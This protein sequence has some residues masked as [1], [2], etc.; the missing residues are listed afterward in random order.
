MFGTF[1]GISN[2]RAIANSAL[3][4]DIIFGGQ[5]SGV[6]LPLM[7]INSSETQL[8]SIGDPSN[9]GLQQTLTL[10]GNGSTTLSF[11]GTSALSPL[12]V[13][14]GLAGTTAAQVLA[15]LVTI[16]ALGGNEV[17][18]IKAVGTG[19][20]TFSLNGVSASAALSFQN[21][22]QTFSVVA[23]GTT[24]LSYNGVNATAPLSVTLGT[25]TAAAIQSNLSTI[26]ALSGNITVAPTA[27]PNVFNITFSGALAGVDA[28]Q[29]QSNTLATATTAT[30]IDGS[31]PTA[32]A[33]QANLQ[34]IP[35]LSGNEVQTLAIIGL[36]G[37]ATLS[38]NNTN[39]TSPLT[40][41][42]N[43]S[44]E[45]VLANLQTIPALSNPNDL[46]VSGNNGGPFTIVFTG[47]LAGQNV[48]QI[49]SSDT[50][51]ATTA[52]TIDGG[53]QVVSVTGP[54]GG[55]LSVQFIGGATGTKRQSIGE[56]HARHGH[57]S[58]D[59]EWHWC[60]ERNPNLDPRN[61][62]RCDPVVQ[63][64]QRKCAA[65]RGHHDD[66]CSNPG[67]PGF[68]SRLE[69][70]RGADVEPSWLGGPGHAV[71]QRRQC[72]IRDLD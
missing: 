24:L 15:N 22:V 52:T 46:T 67:P 29:I 19:T 71:L 58:D 49:A 1:N 50:T 42:P 65:D 30:T 16:P 32:A 6:D 27:D 39:A 33:V 13:T 8:L 64:R 56:R 54:V 47:A 62:W 26:A 4:V 63:R 12:S 35:V 48:V 31:T 55:V 69:R 72:L 60:E 61:G 25:T 41:G 14:T 44:N 53:G 59:N 9:T 3:Q 36:G 68:D 51:I 2:A 45:E 66:R 57:G 23:T 40:F 38:F 11:N 70:Q 34:T 17:Q 37:S 18:T 21:E 43:T 5:L 28:F 7:T 10:A 20:T